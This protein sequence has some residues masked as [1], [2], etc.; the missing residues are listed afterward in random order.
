MSILA[1][2]PSAVGHVSEA[3]YSQNTRAMTV[4]INAKPGP[5]SHGT[6]RSKRDA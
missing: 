4:A 3:R 5:M 6:A 2:K 1:V